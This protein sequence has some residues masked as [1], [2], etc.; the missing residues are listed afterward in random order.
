MIIGDG[1]KRMG[2]RD[3]RQLSHDDTGRLVV[4]ALVPPEAL[5][6]PPAVL[7]LV[8]EEHAAAAADVVFQ[9]YLKILL[10][11]YLD[12]AG[13]DP[14]PGTGSKSMETPFMQYRRPDG[15]G[16]SSKTWPKCP[17]QRAQWTSVR[18]IP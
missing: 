13:A 14:V 10:H 3:S 17:L 8:V 11:A 2:L 9:P 1:L 12:F 4:V 16:P 7:A 5:L 15:R 6:N 18:T